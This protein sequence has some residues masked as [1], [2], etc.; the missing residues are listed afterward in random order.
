MANSEII[1][2][3]EKYTSDLYD[4][5]YHKTSNAE[6]AQDLVQDTFVVAVEKIDS[7]QRK[8]SVKTWLFSILNNKI[9]DFYRKK[10]KAHIPFDGSFLSNFFNKDGTWKN[11]SRP[12]EWNQDEGHLLDN[13]EFLGVLKKCMDALPEKWSATVK[14]K[15]LI[16]KKG[17]EI[18]KELG[19]TSSNYWQMIHR[20]KLQLR[21]CIEKNWFI[22]E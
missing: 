10:S 14:L 7:F 16:Q 6:M 21:A 3:V 19:I 15:Y 9:V 5:A 13:Q 11:E 22:A 20:A 12:K 1:E 8:S 4:W 18:C 2:W 17:V